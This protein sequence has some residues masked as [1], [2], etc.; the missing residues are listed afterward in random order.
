MGCH[1][2][3]GGFVPYEASLWLPFAAHFLSPRPGEA[4][5]LEVLGR[6]GA[7]AHRCFYLMTCISKESDLN[8][9]PKAFCLEKS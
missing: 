8:N 4:V 5:E 6:V 1:D 9:P 2:T 3:G 7:F